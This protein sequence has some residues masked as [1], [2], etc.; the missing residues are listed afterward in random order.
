VVYLVDIYVEPESRGNGIAG[1]MLAH[2]RQRAKRH[3]RA[4]WTNTH[5]RNTAMHH[6]LAKAGFEPLSGFAVP[7]LHNQRYFGRM[8]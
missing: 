4:V 7:G 2:L 1:A 6:L 8:L 3:F 5:I